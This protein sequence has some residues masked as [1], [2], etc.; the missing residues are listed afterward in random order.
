VRYALVIALSLLGVTNAL[1]LEKRAVSITEQEIEWRADE[2]TC[3][4][5]YYNTCTGWIWV[6]SGWSPN[7]MM[8]VHFE[9]CCPNS[10]VKESWMY[11]DE[12]APSGYAFEGVIAIHHLEGPGDCAFNSAPL[13]SQPFAPW[14]GWNY[15]EW[16]DVGVAQNFAIMVTMGPGV[17]NPIAI[18]TDHPMQGPTGPQACGSCYPVNRTN[19]SFYYGTPGTLLCPGSPMNDGVCDAE[20]LWDCTIDCALPSAIEATSWGK[21]KGLYR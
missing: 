16:P 9:A 15:F 6:W 5:L 18:T 20:F 1:A 11:V 19:H 7:D 17:N 4:L 3:K 12:G 21:V 2:V 13:A 8:A 10:K 14:Y